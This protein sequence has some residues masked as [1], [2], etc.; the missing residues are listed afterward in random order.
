MSMVS[1]QRLAERRRW[2]EYVKEFS[3]KSYNGCC[4]N[5]EVAIAHLP[6]R[7]SHFWR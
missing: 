7:T 6:E 5:P 4:V 2:D 3:E 1:H